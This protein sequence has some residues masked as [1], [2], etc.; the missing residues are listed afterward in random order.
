MDLKIEKGRIKAL[1]S[2]SEVYKIEIDIAALPRNPVLTSE[3]ARNPGAV[4][5]KDERKQG[6]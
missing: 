5:V 6:M 3:E 1:V 4:R 2:G